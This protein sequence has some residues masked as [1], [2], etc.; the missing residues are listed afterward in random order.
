MARMP[1]EF[2]KEFKAKGNRFFE[3]AALLYANPDHQ[4]TQGE[5]A[6]TFD[7]ST[8]TISNHIGTMSEWLD[9]RDGQTTYAWGVDVHDPGHTETTMAVQRFYADLWALL[10]KHSRTGPGAF[11][12]LGFVMLLT[13]SVV[14]SIYVGF[15]LELFAESALPA[16]VY[17]GTAIVCLFT[18]VLVTLCSPYMAWISGILWPRL[19]D[20]PFE[21]E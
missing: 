2:A 7:C 15:V 3:I 20:S 4:Y 9:R 12:L 16:S 10:K 1:A 14:L 19:P 11:A 13:G 21:K 8:T 17:L 5:L 6:E 18:G